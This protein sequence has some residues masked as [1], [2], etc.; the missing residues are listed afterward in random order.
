MLLSNPCEDDESLCN[1]VDN[2]TD[3]RDEAANLAHSL[4]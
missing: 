2:Q 3:L 1:W 4:I